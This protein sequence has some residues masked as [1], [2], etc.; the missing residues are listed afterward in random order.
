MFRALSVQ[1]LLP[2]NKMKE[3]KLPMTIVSCCAI[4]SSEGRAQS[5]QILT[6][7]MNS[8][9]FYPEGQSDALQEGLLSALDVRN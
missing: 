8:Y 7:L 1:H 2:L 6:L 4:V 5:M 9:M 3:P